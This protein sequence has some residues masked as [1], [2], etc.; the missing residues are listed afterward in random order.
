MKKGDACI[1][2]GSVW[3]GAGA[4]ITSDQRRNIYSMHMVKGFLRA[5]EN[6]YLAIPRE[7]VESY[8]PEVQTLIGY[9][10]SQ[11]YCGYVE[12]DDPIALVSKGDKTLR[13]RE[14]QGIFIEGPGSENYK[15]S[16]VEAAA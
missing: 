9:S 4:N 1:I 2:I 6:Q 13:E 16:E 7:V 3:H 5:D 10:V 15:P 11:P 8:S 12:L 14:L